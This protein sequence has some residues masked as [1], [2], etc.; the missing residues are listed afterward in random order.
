M[1]LMLVENF[2]KGVLPIQSNSALKR[3]GKDGYRDSHFYYL[4]IDL[5]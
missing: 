4:S 5:S 1:Q 2:R 3:L